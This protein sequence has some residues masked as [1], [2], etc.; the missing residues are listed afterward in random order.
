MATP[1]VSFASA[2]KVPNISPLGSHTSQDSLELQ[3][4]WDEHIYGLYWNDL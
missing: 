3:N 2:L 1:K 4:L